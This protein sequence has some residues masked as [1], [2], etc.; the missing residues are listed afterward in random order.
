M[1]PKR[2]TPKIHCSHYGKT[3]DDDYTFCAFYGIKLQSQ[4][5]STDRSIEGNATSEEKES[6]NIKEW[7]IVLGLLIAIGLVIASF[8]DQVFFG[9]PPWK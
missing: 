5:I 1:L 3:I 9:A 7:L 2:G 8:L 6:K 4:V